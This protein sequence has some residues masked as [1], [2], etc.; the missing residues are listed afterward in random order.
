[1]NF[2][3]SDIPTVIQEKID[4]T[5]NYLTSLW[6]GDMIMVTKGDE[7]KYRKTCLQS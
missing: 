3:L 1:M 4:Q 7:E 5:L 6:L 2:I